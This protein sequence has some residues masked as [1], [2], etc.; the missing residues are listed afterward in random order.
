MNI[1][2]KIYPLAPSLT[3]LNRIL[4][5]IIVATTA[6]IIVAC[7]IAVFYFL[8]LDD[9]IRIGNFKVTIGGFAIPPS[10]YL[11]GA[12]L[13]N[14]CTDKKYAIILAEYQKLTCADLNM[15]DET[16]RFPAQI[17][18]TRAK[19]VEGKLIKM[20]Y[21]I[22][23]ITYSLKNGETI[24]FNTHQTINTIRIKFLGEKDI[25]H[26]FTVLDNDR[27][28]IEYANTILKKVERYKTSCYL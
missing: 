12:K 10:Y 23:G 9:G 3:E 11:I 22:N 16:L 14:T 8:G 21:T 7:V 27:L 24:T 17:T 25:V 1:K 5:Q 26:R 2:T 19:G 18:L 28:Y 6:I 4:T 13:V 20:K 15:I